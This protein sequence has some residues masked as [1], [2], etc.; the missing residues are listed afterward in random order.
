MIDGLEEVGFAEAGAAVEEE[1]V[2]GGAGGVADGDAT[3]VGETV[4]GADDE[5]VEG[6]LRVERG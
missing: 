3:G 1:R 5:V 2:V 6:V 4:A